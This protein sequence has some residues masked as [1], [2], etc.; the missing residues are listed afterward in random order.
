MKKKLNISLKN[1]KLK[2]LIRFMKCCLLFILIGIGSCFAN[3]TYSQRTF[4]T[5]EY[6]NR[7]VKEIIREIEQNSEYIF[8]YLD[9]S[10]NLN[11]KVSVK[12]D[13]E[14]VEKILDQLFAGTRNQYYI[15][16]RQIVISSSKMPEP[17]VLLPIVQQ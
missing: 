4:F 1:A 14:T 10:V 11:R 3:E 16:D 17:P 12:A 9:N 5:F 6:K 7:T 8:F 15:S 2:K 13:N